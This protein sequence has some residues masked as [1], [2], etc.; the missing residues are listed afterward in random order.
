MVMA[1]EKL[2]GAAGDRV[3]LLAPV[4]RDSALL[5]DVLAASGVA[6][7]ACG[8]MHELASKVGENA[9][10]VLLTEEALGAAALPELVDVLKMQ[11]PWSDLSVLV[12]ATA[13]ETTLAAVEAVQTLRCA[14]N[15]TVLDRPV[16]ALTLVTALD[17]ALRA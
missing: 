12:L 11:P 16:R 1:D 9:G 14:G 13:E 4:G 10:A 3:L 6:S 17:S 8:N 15:V 2:G 7:V 5:S